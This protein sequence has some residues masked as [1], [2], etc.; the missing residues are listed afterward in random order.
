M[1]EAEVIAELESSG[2]ECIVSLPCDKNKGFT[3]A[4]HDRFRVIDVTREEDGVGICAG[5]YLAGSRPIMSIQSSGIGNMM[6]A[7]MS[8]TSCYGMPLPILASWRGVD[9]EKIE[10]QIPFNSR[11]PDLLDSYGI[12]YSEI[13]SS[14][15]IHLI[16]EGVRRAFEEG[17]IVVF[18]I[19]P[20]LWGDSK[21]S[22]VSYPPRSRHVSIHVEKDIT[23][24][25]M[26]RLEAISSVMKNVQSGDVVVS[27][28]GVPSKEVFSSMD[29]SLNFYML[30]SYTQATPIGLGIALFSGRRVTVIDGDGSLLGSSVFPVLSSEDPDNLTVI[31]MDNGT[32]GSTGNQI[33]QAYSTVDIG[34]VAGG[35]GLNVDSVSDAEGIVSAMGKVGKGTSFIQVMIRPG[36]SESPNIRM[37]AAEIRDRFMGA[38]DDRT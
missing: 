28:I 1:N 34:L 32:F 26:T 19:H 25:T 12:R 5:A 21:R 3:D 16:G 4:I 31:C 14:D 6:N 7:M 8:L 15:D 27:N 29:R 9:G 22:G 36:N 13:S 24:P 35:Y 11:L 30:G 17:I 2:I 18:L 33:N 37:S 38:M 20:K 23:E 10:A